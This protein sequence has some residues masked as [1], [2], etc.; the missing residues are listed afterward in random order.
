MRPPTAQPLQWSPGLETQPWL[1]RMP[2]THKLQ[3]RTV[4]HQRALGPQTPRDQQLL[5]PLQEAKSG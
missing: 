4:P 5:T 3:L 2:P 1:P